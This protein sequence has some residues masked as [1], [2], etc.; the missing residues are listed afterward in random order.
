MT[1]IVV[2]N[3]K[4]GVGKSTLAT[5]LAGFLAARGDRV[6]LA[7]LDP[8][9]S[10]RGWLNLR[11]ATLPPIEPL[12]IDPASPGKLPRGLDHV[13]I[14]TPAGL[15][16]AR[17]DVSLTFAS[18]IVVPV[19]PSMFDILA[20]NDFLINLSQQKALRKGAAQAA[21]VGMRVDPRTRSA[22]ELNRYMDGLDLPVLTCLRDTQNYVQIAAHGASLWDVAPGRVEKDFQQ[23]QPLLDWL[24][25]GD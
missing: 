5:N 18:R 13:I 11:P 22:E 21:I 1:V 25:L 17:L 3:P 14:D 9:Q 19:L 2:A 15:H 7:D 20:I 16:G 10:S 12:D 23:W 8:Q 4:G 24:G 6:A